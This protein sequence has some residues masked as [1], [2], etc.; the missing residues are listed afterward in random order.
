MVKTV[1]F[2]CIFYHNKKNVNSNYNLLSAYDMPGT[3]SFKYYTRINSVK[4][5]GYMRWV[6]SIPT[7]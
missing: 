7:L 6:L 3:V 1:N 5:L 2:T 4:T